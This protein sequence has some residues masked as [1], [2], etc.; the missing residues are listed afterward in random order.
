MHK[1]RLPWFVHHDERCQK[2]QIASAHP[3]NQTDPKGSRTVSKEN[4]SE[5]IEQIALC[6]RNLHGSSY[7]YALVLRQRRG[8]YPELGRT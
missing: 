8:V 7:A 2:L 5:T 4:T 1:P 3:S 6:V